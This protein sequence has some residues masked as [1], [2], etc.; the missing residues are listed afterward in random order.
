MLNFEKS[1]GIIYS[2]LASV[3]LTSAYYLIKM[4]RILNVSDMGAINFV[5]TI[6]CC[7]I[8]SLILRKNPFGETENRILLVLRGLS[9]SIGLVLTFFSIEFMN[10]GDSTVIRNISPI[11]TALFARIFLKERLNV[12]HLLA[13]IVSIGGI[14]FI[15]RPA[16]IF[17]HMIH[18]NQLGLTWKLA[19]GITLGLLSTFAIGSAFIFIKKLTNEKVHFVAIVF[20]LSFVGLILCLVGSI[21]LYFA[22]YSIQNWHEAKDYLLRDIILAIAAGI[23]QFI[24]HFCFIQA[25]TRE[26][27]NTISIMR[28]FDILVA[29]IL[30]YLVL[31]I[32]PDLFSFIG[33]LMVFIS[34]LIMFVYKLLVV[35]MKEKCNSNNHKKKKQK[36]DVVYRI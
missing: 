30:E 14:L 1:S 32:I 35:N 2:L 34:I 5:S 29:F 23:L 17:G 31:Q 20:Y 21:I 13:L 25:L 7:F 3:Y 8:C 9:G 18:S 6:I 33:A 11:I 22:G 19:I 26:N 24:G 28:T 12:S 10:Y 36:E 27:A 16:F 15:A 4:G